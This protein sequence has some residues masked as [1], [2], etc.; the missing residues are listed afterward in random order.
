MALKK[1]K[2]WFKTYPYWG[3]VFLYP[4]TLALIGI[5]LVAYYM[6]DSRLFSSIA[7]LFSLPNL[8]LMRFAWIQV[9]QQKT[10]RRFHYAI[11][12]TSIILT[13]PRLFFFFPD[14]RFFHFDYGLI[15][16]W[17]I[18]F[19]LA[20]TRITIWL[21]KRHQAKKAEANHDTNG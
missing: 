2:N 20:I 15:F 7:N 19:V 9:K 18:V 13:T 21:Y 16:L 10:L 5:I 4:M 17:F 14:V 3:D 6:N 11:G 8:L 1:S 12:F